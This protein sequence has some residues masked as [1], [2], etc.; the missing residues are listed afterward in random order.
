MKT[1][2]ITTL[3]TVAALGWLTSVAVV[4]DS[5]PLAAVT[6]LATQRFELGG[7]RMRVP[8]EFALETRIVSYAPDGTRG[9]TD[10]YRLRLRSTPAASGEKTGDTITCLGF[11]VQLG[12]QAE[13]EIP[14]LKGL[15]YVPD[16]TPESGTGG[17][18]VLGVPHAPFENLVDAARRPVP[19]GN[20]YHVYNAFVDFH[21]FCDVFPRPMGEQAGVEDLHRLGQKLV[22]ATAGSMPPV[23]VGSV[24]AEGSFFK[25]GEVT[26]ALKGLGAVDGTTCAVLGVDSG[27]S[28]FAMLM[29]PTPGMEIRTTGASHYQGDIYLNLATHW[30]SRVEADEVVVSRTKLPMPPNQIDSII[31]RTIL[32]RNVSAPSARTSR[33][34]DMNPQRTEGRGQSEIQGAAQGPPKKTPALE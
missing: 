16:L 12:E 32:I 27:R 2:L 3:F 29:R 30:V 26:L 1:N 33:R 14:S 11:T 6:S 20:S 18:P 34:A 4:G 9:V 31:E 21:A 22:H 5:V 13:S 25:N 19:A 10:I 8:Q 23:N 24:V 17:R 28:S 7:G 15:T